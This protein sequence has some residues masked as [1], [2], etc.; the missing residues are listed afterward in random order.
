MQPSASWP[1]WSWRDGRAQSK[2]YRL[3]SEATGPSETSYP[4]KMD[5]SWKQREWW[6]QSHCAR[7]SLKTYTIPTK[8]MRKPSW[9]PKTQFTGTRS[10][11][12]SKSWSKAVPFARSTSHPTK[13]KPRPHEIPQ[14]PWEV[15]GIDLFHFQGAEYM[16]VADYYGKYFVVRR[17]GQNTT[18]SST[19]IR[20]LKQILAEHGI[21]GRSSAIMVHSSTQQSSNSLQSNG[22]STT[23][24]HPPVTLSPMASSN[25]MSKTSKRPWPKPNKP[26]LT[27]TWPCCVCA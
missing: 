13:R 15:I 14:R 4:L 10:T 27:L 21:P 22:L 9:E 24:P 6:Y 1:V 12:T 17:H 23:L 26:R 16:P 5:S 25:A 18:R 11:K 20:A 2:R 19:V 3:P 8:G 7:T